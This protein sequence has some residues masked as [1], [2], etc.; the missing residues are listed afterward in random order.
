M[1]DEGRRS[2]R[3][4]WVSGALAALSGAAVMLALFG[5]RPLDPGNQGWLWGELGVDPIQHWLGWTYYRQ[6][7]WH[8][9][10]GTNPEYGLELGS[11]IYFADAVPLVAMP[12]KALRGLLEVP[13]YVLRPIHMATFE[14]EPPGSASLQPCN[15]CQADQRTGS[16]LV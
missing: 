2:M 8:W 15:R 16:A 3:G 9:P 6:T 4:T 13:Q 7:S 14:P 12:L 11:A 1:T 5:L 10:P